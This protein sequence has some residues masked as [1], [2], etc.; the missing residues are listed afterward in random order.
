MR[1]KT[2]KDKQ[3]QTSKGPTWPPNR[4]QPY[5]YKKTENQK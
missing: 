3:K 5:L 2:T 4:V 1:G